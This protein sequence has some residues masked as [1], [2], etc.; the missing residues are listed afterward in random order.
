VQAVE[1][2][3]VEI[4]VG[5]VELEGV[6]TELSGLIMLS[7]VVMLLLILVVAVAVVQGQMEVEA[8]EDQV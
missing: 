7:A 8:M 1:G 4:L 5:M 3:T 6:V 2:V